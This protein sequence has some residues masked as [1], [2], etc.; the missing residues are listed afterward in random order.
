MVN[1]FPHLFSVLLRIRL[2]RLCLAV[3][4][5]SCAASALAVDSSIVVRTDAAGLKASTNLYGIFIED[6]CHQVEGGIYAEMLRNRNFDD[7]KSAKEVL[8]AGFVMRLQ[9]NASG[10]GNA[11]EVPGWKLATAKPGVATWAID[12]SQPLNESNPRSLK[13]SVTEPGPRT[14]IYNEGHCNN[15]AGIAVKQGAAYRFSCFARSPLPDTGLTVSIESPDGQIL[16]SQKIS[17]LNADW[18]KYEL[19]LTPS[20]SLTGARLFIAPTAAGTCFLDMVSLFPAATWKNRPN[21]LR[22]DLMEMVAAM[23]PA[24]VRFPGGCFVEGLELENAW[25]WKKTIGP[26][27]ERPGHWNIW[28]WR[29]SDGMGYF[30]YLQM[31]EDLGAEPIH[32]INDGISHTA[33]D[34]VQ[35]DGVYS[36]Q[37]MEKMDALVQDGLDSIEFANG[38]TNSTW[39][40]RRA[41]MGHP[42]P[43]NL[44]F[45]EVGNENFGPEYAKRY[46]LFHDAIRAK[47]PGIKLLMDTWGPNNFPTNRIPDLRDI[48]RFATPYEFALRYRQFDD[49]DRTG[50]KVYFGEW[51]VEL[52]LPN[53]ESLETGLYEGVFLTGLEKNSDHV[54]MTSYAPFMNNLGW[55]NAKPNMI[56]FDL[57]RVYGAPIYWLQ[58]MFAE[59]RVD[60]LLPFTVA[61]PDYRSAKLGAL[62]VGTQDTAA[63][64]KDIVV[65]DANGK[66]TFDA[67]AAS[68]SAWSNARWQNPAAGSSPRVLASEA[69]GGSM[70]LTRQDFAGPCTIS[71]KAQKLVGKNGFQ[72]YFNTYF[73]TRYFWQLGGDGNKSAKFVGEG[74]ENSAIVKFVVETNR[75]YDLK[76]EIRGEEI[77]GYVDGALVSEVSYQPL[78]S[79]YVSA[80]RSDSVGEIIIKVIN[81]SPDAQRTQ[82]QLPGAN[83]ESTGESIV[84]T[85]A[86]PLAKNSREQPNTVVPQTASLPNVSADF[87]H[88]FPAYS[89]TVLKLKL[90]VG[91]AAVSIPKKP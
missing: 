63:E 2:K 91:T 89:A 38:P 52:E 65:T 43:F 74:L 47:Y 56:G 46:A 19:T 31:C 88:E 27:E 82:I 15:V 7:T 41:A 28:G 4:L 84:L 8:V 77:K 22:P 44:K 80:G 3:T 60:S 76:L 85:S 39:G 58:R 68:A 45:I 9:E 69:K 49:Y 59:N 87:A 51:C 73:N 66:V 75:W 13:L 83:L 25:H 57:D 42:A 16:A 5:V 78:Q 40:A 90:A 81:I 26:V 30:E 24:F 37:P 71:L 11:V 79:L 18:K 64:F 17:G 36:Y 55:Q 21:G 10:G 34:G 62:G 20:A 72:I 54:L 14:G 29:S 1:Q 70:M 33:K 6:W 23:K 32:V 67:N 48:H 61:S 12:R 35:L 50:P 86:N 53:K